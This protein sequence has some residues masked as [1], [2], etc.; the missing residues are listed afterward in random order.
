MSLN[1]RQ[2]LQVSPAARVRWFWSVHPTPPYSLLLSVWLVVTWHSSSLPLWKRTCNDFRFNFT[3]INDTVTKLK[4]R[5]RICQPRRFSCIVSK[6]ES[7][8]FS[9]L[10]LWLD[11]SARISDNISVKSP[12]NSATNIH[13]LARRQHLWHQMERSGDRAKHYHVI[14]QHCKI[15]HIHKEIK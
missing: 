12:P 14:I 13:T 5:T 4:F 1:S 7:K 11:S 2:C 9:Y 3:L 6:T 15:L 8:L 10:S